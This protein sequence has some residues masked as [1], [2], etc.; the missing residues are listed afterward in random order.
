MIVIKKSGR[1]HKIPNNDFMAIQDTSDGMYFRFKDGSELRIL[2][3]V[4][5]QVQAASKVLMNSTAK[6]I[7]LD[8]DGPQLIHITG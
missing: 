5:P 6:E 4:T 1:E 7:T 3:Q 2:C 8:F